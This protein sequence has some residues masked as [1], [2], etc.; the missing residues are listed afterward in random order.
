MCGAVVTPVS[1][2]SRYVKFVNVWFENFFGGV[3]ME[4]QRK[5]D[6]STAELSGQNLKD[7]AEKSV[8]E[9]CKNLSALWDIVGTV[10][11]LLT[12]IVGIVYPIS[13]GD[14]FTFI[15]Y[16]VVAVLIYMIFASIS[17]V[18]RYISVK[19]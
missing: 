7:E 12:V 5:N 8:K 15:I 11:A 3:F 18:L 1:I 19:K 10:L 13:T 14:F 9:N 2:I 4:E 17:A 6:T 16:A